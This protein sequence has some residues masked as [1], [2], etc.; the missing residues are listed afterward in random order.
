MFC[1][2]VQRRDLLSRV[3]VLTLRV[4]GHDEVCTAVSLERS[5]VVLVLREQEIERS[6]ERKERERT[7]TVETTITVL[8]GAR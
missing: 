7:H 2:I 1:E 4:T 8:K 3:P 5:V 6:R